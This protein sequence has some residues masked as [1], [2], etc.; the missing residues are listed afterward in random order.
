M[1]PSDVKDEGFPAP[2]KEAVGLID[3]VET[4][5]TST[6][7]A[8]KIMITLSQE[9]RLS[10]WIQVPLSAPSSASVEMALPDTSLLPLSHLTPKTLLGGG[11]E[12]RESSGQLYAVQ[13]ASLFARRDSEEKRTLLVG[14]GLLKPKPD[15]ESFFDLIELVQRVI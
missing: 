5:A 13:I 14:L 10:Q 3:G 11:G 15:R 12:E 2:S 1:A 7:F 4:Q 9:G 8:D 6:F